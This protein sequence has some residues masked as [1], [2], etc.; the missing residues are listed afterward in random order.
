[1]LAKMSHTVTH[2]SGRVSYRRVYPRALR[3]FIPDTPVELKIS[4]GR[5]ED[6]DYGARHDSA[7]REYDAIVAKARAA[8]S[9]ALTVMTHADAVRLAE[10]FRTQ[11][12]IDDDAARWDQSERDVYAGVLG[13]LQALGLEFHS[14]WA[15]RP[16]Q[17][18]GEKALADVHGH[19]K[20]Y[21]ALRGSGNLNGIIAAW[22]EEAVELAALAGF[23]LRDDDRQSLALLCRAINDAAISADEDRVRRHAGEDVPTPEM[24]ALVVTGSE[25]PAAVVGILSTFDGYAAAQGISAGVRREW[26]TAIQ[27]LIEFLGHDD[28]GALTAANLRDWRDALLLEKTAKGTLRTARTV[29][30]KYLTPIKAALNWAVEEQRIAANVATDVKVRVMKPEKLREKSYTEEEA[31]TILKAARVEASDRHSAP[32]ARARR[33]VPWLC[34]Y[35]GARVNEITQLRR[36]DIRKEEGVWTM[37]ITPE[38]GNVKNRKARTVPLHAHLIEQGFIQMVEGL[39]AGPM[40]YD[41]TKRHAGNEESRQHKKVGERL[42]A[43]VR[44]TVKITDP[45]IAPNH[46]FRDTFKTRAMEVGIQERVADAIEGHAPAS[47]G[48]TYGHASIKTLATAMRLFPRFD[49]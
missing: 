23:R 32:S 19:L 33:W 34:A 44:N 27:R 29:R 8:Q 6:A 25:A 15:D 14:P 38:A 4:I 24:P 39:E 7:R 46:A 11:R 45:N 41:V 1:M 40:F 17:R 47:V 36:E 10:R 49:A 22:H 21:K 5:P 2:A 16:D 12:L 37:R 13:Q 3:P 18:W 20:E 31:C 28:A 43:W 26:R 30:N 48:Q 9:G 42:A 35:S